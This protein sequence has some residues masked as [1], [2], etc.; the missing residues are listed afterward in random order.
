LPGVARND[1][2][3]REGGLREAQRGLQRDHVQNRARSGSPAHVDT[4]RVALR[5]TEEDG[6]GPPQQRVGTAPGPTGTPDGVDL[7]LA[8]LLQTHPVVRDLE[9]L[10]ARTLR[11]HV[12]LPEGAHDQDGGDLLLGGCRRGPLAVV[13]L[14]LAILADAARLVQL[15]FRLN[16]TVARVLQLE[17]VEHPLSRRNPILDPQSTFGRER[18]HASAEGARSAG[19]RPGHRT[20]GA[21]TADACPAYEEQQREQG[22]RRPPPRDT[23]SAL[24]YRHGSARIADPSPAGRAPARSPPK[25]TRYSMR[26]PAVS[27]RCF[28]R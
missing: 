8:I 3:G 4:Q 18:N 2:V 16:L 14:Q 11:G 19:R 5:I 10:L 7:V 15:V 23:T 26:C 17:P 28:S 9:N 13:Q 20:L 25:P 1:L 6:E 22:L 24:V 12:L 27:S 21:T